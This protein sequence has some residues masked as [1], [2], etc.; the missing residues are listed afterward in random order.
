MFT[1]YSISSC[2]RTCSIHFFLIGVVYYLVPVQII[3]VSVGM[4]Q[5][6]WRTFYLRLLSLIA[7]HVLVQ[8]LCG[9]QIKQI[10]L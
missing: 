10:K 6:D 1:I 2:H 7:T 8:L 5:F 9:V 4:V 3:C